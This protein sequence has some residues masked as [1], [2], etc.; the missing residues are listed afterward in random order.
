MSQVLTVVVQ[1]LVNYRV[2]Y[3]R[4]PTSLSKFLIL[5][6][7]EAFR[8]N[9]PE[10]LLVNYFLITVIMFTIYYGGRS[11]SAYCQE[12]DHWWLCVVKMVCSSMF[13][14]PRRL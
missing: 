2:L 9:P 3:K 8:Q 7:R 11:E 13:L 5:K 14:K 4:E 12:V 1:R 6:A 10:N